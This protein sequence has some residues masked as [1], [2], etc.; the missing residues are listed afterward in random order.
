MEN[1]G[2]GIEV[3]E[4]VK[5]TEEG[6]SK[7]VNEKI[8]IARKKF[9]KIKKLKENQ[10]SVIDEEMQKN[11]KNEIKK[12]A[13]LVKVAQTHMQLLNSESKRIRK[14]KERMIQAN[15][16][17]ENLQ[18]QSELRRKEITEKY[19]NGLL[20]FFVALITNNRKISRVKN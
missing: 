17:F 18:R 15:R 7:E 20:P 13:R 19:Y 9:D 5:K 6:S 14:N 2:N 11:L 12:K 10:Q 1:P 4:E 8:E 16:R 3:E